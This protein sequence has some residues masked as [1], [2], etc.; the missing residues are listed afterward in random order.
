MLCCI[1]WVIHIMM[2]ALEFSPFCAGADNPKLF[3]TATSDMYM[4][5]PDIIIMRYWV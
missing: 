3:S 4:Y 5:M 1:Q 2:T